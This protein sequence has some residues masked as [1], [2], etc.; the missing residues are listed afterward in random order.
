MVQSKMF[1]IKKLINLRQVI[2]EMSINKGCF[3]REFQVF[4]VNSL[5][6]RGLIEVPLHD[7]PASSFELSLPSIFVG[8]TDSL[9]TRAF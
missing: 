8:V 5:V 1:F 4:E 6:I 7:G 3:K 9:I 2:F